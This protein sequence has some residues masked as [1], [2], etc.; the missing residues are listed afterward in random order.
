LTITIAA[1][2]SESWQ[3]AEAHGWHAEPRTFRV[4]ARLRLRRPG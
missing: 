3:T 2:I 1:L 4:S